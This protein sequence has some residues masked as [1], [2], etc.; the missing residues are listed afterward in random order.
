MATPKKTFFVAL[1]VTVAS[2]VLGGVVGSTL[3]IHDPVFVLV[4]VIFLVSAITAVISGFVV[5]GRF[6]RGGK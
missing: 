6:L 5:F 1:V 3:S 2:Y 4:Y